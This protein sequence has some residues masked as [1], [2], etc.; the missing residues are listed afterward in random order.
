MQR[1][2][3]GPSRLTLYPV[4]V[5]NSNPK[6]LYAAF[7]DSKQVREPDLRITLKDPTA[8]RPAPGETVTISGFISNYSETPFMFILSGAEIVPANQANGRRPAKVEQ[9]Q[10][11]SP[12]K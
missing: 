6:Y 8:K 7:T 3:T 11:F 10:P 4:L 5:L 2:A 9:Q 12:V 1:T